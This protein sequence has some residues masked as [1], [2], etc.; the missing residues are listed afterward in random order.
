MK[1]F[2]HDT[3]ASSD[4]KLQ[5]VLVTY[6]AAGYGLYWYCLECIAGTVTEHNL[7]FE[8]EHDAELL[9]HALSLSPQ[10]VTEMMALMVRLRLFE[11]DMGGRVHCLKM[12]TRLDSSMTSSGVFRKM[13]TQA[14]EDY[15]EGGQ[16]SLLGITDGQ[17]CL[18]HDSIMQEERRGEENRTEESIDPAAPAPRCPYSLIVD[19]YHEKLPTLPRVKVLTEK[20]KKAVKARHMGIM[21]ST[22]NNWAEY[23]QKASSSAFLMGEIPGKDWRA[24]FDFLITEKA[25]IGVLEGKY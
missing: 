20:R 2:K 16:G 1:W 21:E 13:I 12:L 8:L 25:A 6:G 19:L 23:F 9:A 4:A 17:S 5:K 3:N 10:Q 7:T 18:G 24:D 22:L 11:V 15:Q 14:K